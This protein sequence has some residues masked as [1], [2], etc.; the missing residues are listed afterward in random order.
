M[1][2]TT[3][4]DAIFLG[5]LNRSWPSAYS[6]DTMN[7]VGNKIWR[8]DDVTSKGVG[9][10][11]ELHEDLTFQ[12]EPHGNVSQVAGSHEVQTQGL[13]DHRLA[14]DREQHSSRELYRYREDNNEAAFAGLKEDMDARSDVYVL[15]NGCRKSRCGD[16]VVEKN[17][18][19]LYL[20]RSQEYH[21]V[22]TRPDITSTNVV[23]MYGF[24]IQGC[25]GRRE[26]KVLH[27]IALSTTEA[28]YM[29][30]TKA[31]RLNG[32]LTES[33]AE[34]RLLAVFAIDALT[35]AIPCLRF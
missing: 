3:Y 15:N 35:K 17:D 11:V 10:E 7:L 25:G 26:A 34:L 12:V 29:T 30:L 33:G 22:Y 2:I 4:F 18:K 32:L 24:M 28:V 13:I 6:L 5:C 8:L 20:V 19:W 27:M 1:A 16:C 14:R 21:I 31:I 9:F 23:T